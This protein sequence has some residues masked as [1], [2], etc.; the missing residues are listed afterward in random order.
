MSISRKISFGL[1]GVSFCVFGVGDYLEYDAPDIVGV[2]L[3]AVAVSVC[4][5]LYSLNTEV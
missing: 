1:L 2:S 4:F 5:F 3:L